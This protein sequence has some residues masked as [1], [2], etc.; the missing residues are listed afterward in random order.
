MLQ[1][2]DR[3][4]QV[5]A[6][7][8]PVTATVTFVTYLRRIITIGYGFIDLVSCMVGASDNTLAAN[9]ILSLRALQ[10]GSYISVWYGVEA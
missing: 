6:G 5:S 1:T 2:Y 7:Y 9:R 4:R 8:Q 3:V 10:S